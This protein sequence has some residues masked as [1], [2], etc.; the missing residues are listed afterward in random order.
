M[1]T[2]LGEY[3]EKLASASPADLND[4]IREVNHA[5]ADLVQRQQKAIR[6]IEDKYAPKKWGVYVGGALTVAGAASTLLLP[7]LAP[8]LGLAAP[9]IAAAAGVAG[10]FV[11]YGKE[12]AGELIEKRR[13]SKTMLGMLAVARPK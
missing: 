9:A 8:A 11:G 6:D 10:T 2:E 13:A 4:V 7:S 12:K 5:L 3:T 1:R